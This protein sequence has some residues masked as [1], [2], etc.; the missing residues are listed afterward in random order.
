MGDKTTALIFLVKDQASGAVKG[1]ENALN[2]LSHKA[3]LGGRAMSG[4]QNILRGVGYGI[5]IG[6]FQEFDKII[7]KI[8]DAIP[9][10][11]T[12]ALSFAESVKQIHLVTGGTDEQV[13]RLLG[14]FQ[15]LG[16]SSEGLAQK[17]GIVAK[18]AITHADALRRVGVDI[19]SANT[20]FDNQI[21]ILDKLR[22]ALNDVSGG[23]ARQAVL[24]SILGRNA[25]TLTEYFSL[26]NAQVALLNSEMDKL[27]VT[28]DEQGVA[29]AQAVSHEFNLFGLSVQGV[30]NKLLS[31]VA[32]ALQ[33]AVDGLANFVAENGQA[34][35]NFASNVVNFVFGMIDAL[36][37]ANLAA[38]PFS[39]QMEALAG[40]TTDAGS[41]LDSYATKTKAGTANTAAAVRAIDD[42]I[43]ALKAE[44]SA[45]QKLYD[46]EIGGLTKTLDLEIKNLDAVLKARQ[47]K[48]SQIALAQQLVDAEQALAEA[49]AGTGGIVDASAVT[50]AYKRVQNIVQ[51]QGDAQLQAG[52]DQRKAEVDGVKSYISDIEQALKDSTDKKALIATLDKDIS[53]LLSQEATAKQAGDLQKVADIDAELQ[54]VRTTKSRAQDQARTTSAET[55]LNKQKDALRSVG[56]AID[57]INPH[58]TRLGTTI[59]RLAGDTT[60]EMH[61]IQASIA[62]G[63]LV[64]AFGEAALAGATFGESIKTAL[65]DVSAAIA[66]PVDLL[67]KFASLIGGITPAEVGLALAALGA[68]TGNI[69]LALAGLALMGIVIATAKTP[70]GPGI[71]L[72]HPLR[73]PLPGAPGGGSSGGG[74]FGPVLGPPT[75]PGALP[76]QG[77][78]TNNIYLDG[79]KIAESTNRILFGTS[80]LNALVNG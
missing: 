78:I 53:D 43:S 73:P 61:G 57:A 32:P 51:Q 19:G 16:I 58:V 6:G 45:A 3:D 69:P 62:P 72:G 70:S 14:T 11:I 71:A 80:K 77:N 52:I 44:D 22:S 59:T 41:S 15:Y 8:T 24:Q 25:A 49:R 4:L 12:K 26:T 38:A 13:S 9:S 5:G 10:L 79:Q 30:A 48:E 17:F 55:A 31:D 56:G 60:S 20:G 36:T 18:N 23:T 66:A 67:G 1:L 54:A 68:V 27:G 46:R 39:A 65:S 2:S 64:G 40:T 47:S 29:K 42:K 50:E 76:G 37:G 28:L 35:A 33:S 74:T 34:I 75:P 63:G 21:T 7:G